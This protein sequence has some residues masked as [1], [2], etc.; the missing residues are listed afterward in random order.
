MPTNEQK[1]MIA[2][3]YGVIGEKNEA[4][5]R[6]TIIQ[7]EPSKEK[8]R[9]TYEEKPPNNDIRALTRP[10]Q[11]RLVKLDLDSPRMIQAMKNIGLTRDDLDTKKRPEDFMYSSKVAG[12]PM[13]PNEYDEN[14]VD[15]RFRHYQQRLMDRINK[16]V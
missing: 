6:G 7:T 14:V 11:I 9:Q 5:R 4:L 2:S 3:A 15:L 10:K 1:G 12:Q 8:P 13:S 16:V